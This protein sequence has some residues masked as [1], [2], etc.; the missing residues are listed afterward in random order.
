M[1]SESSGLCD[2]SH[3]PSDHGGEKGRSQFRVSLRPRLAAFRGRAK[4]WSPVV[5]RVSTLGLTLLGLAAIGLAAGTSPSF[6]RV[7]NRAPAEAIRLATANTWL[8]PVSV[9]DDDAQKSAH[10]VKSEQNT[11]PRPGAN[12]TRAPI[13]CDKTLTPSSPKKKKRGERAGAKLSLNSATAAELRRLPGI[14][15]K[16]ARQIIELRRRLGG[17]SRLTDLLRV[18][19]IGAKSL[20]KLLPFLRLGEP[21]VAPGPPTDTEQAQGS[22]GVQR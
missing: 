9:A 19:G 8:R 15:Q 5:A 22:A 21:R 17:F 12:T 18:K 16:R 14:G 11:A 3:G 1:R 20:R 6:E 10:Q 2:P 13:P 4:A 7:A